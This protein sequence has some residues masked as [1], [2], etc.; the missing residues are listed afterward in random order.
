[1]ILCLCFKPLCFLIYLAC[2]IALSQNP[3]KLWR[4]MMMMV[5]LFCLFIRFTKLFD[6]CFWYKLFIKFK[7]F[8]YSYFS[9]SLKLFDF[10]NNHI[11]SN[12]WF[13][14]SLLIN[15]YYMFY[16]CKNILALLWL[17]KCLKTQIKQ[18]IAEFNL[19]IFY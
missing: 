7:H 6:V 17:S 4:I 16:Q 8:S 19:L 3:I 1:M 11:D 15:I 14:F 13:T 5:S 2:V 10:I 9:R 18:Y 12:F